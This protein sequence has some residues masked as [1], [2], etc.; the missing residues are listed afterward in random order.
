MPTLDEFEE[1]IEN[2]TW[3][4]VPSDY[5]Q[6][7]ED[8]P[9]GWKVTSKINGNSIYLPAAG[10][11]TNENLAKDKGNQAYYW[12]SNR[13][14]DGEIFATNLGRFMDIPFWNYQYVCM[15]CTVRPVHP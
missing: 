6:W 15:G 4:M 13:D 3:E 9:G 14:E 8:N 11:R 1:L 5:H 7:S 2:C 12:T 10:Q